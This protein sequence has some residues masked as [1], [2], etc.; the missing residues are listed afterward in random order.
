[1]TTCGKD[2]A[3]LYGNSISVPE[4][5]PTRAKA[6]ADVTGAGDT[7]C[8]TRA[9]SLSCGAPIEHGVELSNYAAGVVVGK[10]GTATTT[11]EEL[12]EYLT[13]K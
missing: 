12:A 3:F 7:F 1:M 13:G 9:L 10:V 4:L 6:V 11:P 8:V 2:G 5:I